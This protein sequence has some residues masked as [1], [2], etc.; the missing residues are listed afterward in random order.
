MRNPLRLSLVAS[1]FAVAALTSAPAA[2]ADNPHFTKGPTA[3]VTTSGNTLNL[4]LSFK[5]AG[6]GNASA[7][8]NWTLLNG[9]GQL[10]SRCYNKGGNTPE[11]DNKQETVPV[12][13]TF[14]TAVNHGNTTFNGTLK[15]VTST[16]D[17]PGKQI[18]KIESFS[19]SATLSLVGGG[20][21]APLTWTLP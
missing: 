19:A 16:L 15:T 12:A 8:A 5:A 21:S 2:L 9:T 17:C 1:A 7:Y 10:F 3:S 6:L 18:V 13:A 11:A 14:T 4:N 20:L